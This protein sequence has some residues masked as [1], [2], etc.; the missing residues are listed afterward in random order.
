MCYTRTCAGAI[1]A[2]A[3]GRRLPYQKG[4]VIMG[5][6]ANIFRN[7]DWFML[8]DILLRVVPIL[9]SLTV[10]ELAHGLMAFALGDDTAKQQ[11]RLSLNPLRHVDPVGFIM[12]LV[13]RFGWAKPVPVNMNNFKRPK[14]GMAL[15]AFAGPLSNFLFAALIL[16]FQ[17]PLIQL[18]L[19]DGARHYIA[20]TL[21][22]TAS[23]S[24]FLGLFNLLPVPPLD[25]SKIVFSVLGDRLHAKLMHYERFGIFFLMALIFFTGLTD[26]LLHAMNVVFEWIRGLTEAPSIWL[27]DR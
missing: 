22:N 14:F 19:A 2:F 27:F 23:I 8:V 4:G 25:G 18:W 20:V 13:F 21:F 6:F 11:R 3:I 24:V 15:T 26:H 1:R 12:L 10:H 9:L 7:L 17:V 16:L 5:E